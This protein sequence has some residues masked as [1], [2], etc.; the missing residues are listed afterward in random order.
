VRIS[1]IK[2]T[3]KQ[4]ARGRSALA[5]KAPLGYRNGVPLLPMKPGSAKA[6]LKLV[7]QLRDGD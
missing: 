1:T 7:N 5:S 2:T 6:T 3:L 4:L